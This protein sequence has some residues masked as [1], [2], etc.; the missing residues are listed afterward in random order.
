MKSDDEIK[1]ILE[2]SNKPA[3]VITNDREVK[4][5]G[6][7]VIV[8]DTSSVSHLG[9]EEIDPEDICE[10]DYFIVIDKNKRVE[11]TTLTGN[12]Y[13]QDLVIVNP[14]TNW[15]FRVVSRHVKIYLMF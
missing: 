14:K 10:K 12:V 15:Q 2:G 4:E 1:K 7:R 9:G 3:R 13:K 5:I 6:D 11:Y 8:L